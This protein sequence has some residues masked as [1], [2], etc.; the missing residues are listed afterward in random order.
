MADAASFRTYLRDVIGIPD[1]RERREAVRDQ[2]LG[3]IRD[4]LE[5]DKDAIEVL[6]SS[7]RKPGGTI[8]NPDI[9]NPGA[10]AVIPNP[11][12]NIPAI[13]EKRLI[14][15]AYTAKL[16]NM[17][18]RAITPDTMSW[19]RIKKF[20][21]HR[22]L[23]E[24][25]EDPEKLPVVSKSFGIIRAM[26]IVPSHL[27]DRL[28]VRKIPLSY[29]IR[30]TADPGNVPLPQADQPTST[31]FTSI[32]EELIHYA[33]HQGD[34]YEEDN[35][36]VFQIMQDMV[37]G[38]SFESS[39]KGHQRRRDGRA[40]Y[41]A[42]CQHNLGSSKWDKILE[43]AE[44]YVSKR[45]WNGR[46]HR[47]NL[48][49]HI[50]KHREAYNDMV[51]ASQHVE[52]SL[53]NE[54][55][56]VGRLLKSITSKEPSIVSA[57]THIHGTT[58]QRNDFETAADF[59]LLTSPTNT[60]VSNT[61]RI[62]ASRTTSDGGDTKKGPETGVEIRYYTKKEYAKLSQAQRKELAKLRELKNGDSKSNISTVKQELMREMKELENR[63]IAAIS[64][65][66]GTSGGGSGESIVRNPLKNP[67]NQRGDS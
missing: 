4:F 9:A 19:D 60:N 41:L 35:A 54:H 1:P 26:D 50:N 5:L 52:Y 37:A 56:R 44:N 28:G 38:T 64:T 20:D 22:V 12:F 59:L 48:K 32:T 47:F 57:I 10:P 13:C 43:D 21:T 14:A 42:L 3:V 40:A 18:G 2:G 34:E 67:L 23:M 27:R 49:L 61:Q 16:Y 25:H 30:D 62:S 11:G 65:A 51:R 6:C 66:H 33:P 39:V 63:L 29:V 17:I 45:E 31:D 7:V 15:A 8:P 53:P 46:N 36:K 55:T 58:T 24:D